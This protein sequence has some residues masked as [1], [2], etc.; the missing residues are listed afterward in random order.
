MMMVVMAVVHYHHDLRLHRIGYCEAEGE[1]ESEQNFF[2]SLS[3]PLGKSI[4]R[5]KMTTPR[6]PFI[7]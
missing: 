3:M 5:A 1:H 2:H 7:A 6:N 4:Y